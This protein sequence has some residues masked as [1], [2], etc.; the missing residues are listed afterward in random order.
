MKRGCLGAR[1][2]SV[3][4]SRHQSPWI[5]RRARL[6]GRYAIQVNWETWE[7]EGMARRFF[8]KLNRNARLESVT[9]SHLARLA[10]TRGLNLLVC[11][12]HKIALQGL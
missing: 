5:S 8:S 4:P 7:W 2:G 3:D 9:Q 11:C 1:L 6:V 10:A 12:T